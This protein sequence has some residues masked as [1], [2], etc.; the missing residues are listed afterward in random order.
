MV[1]AS[2]PTHWTKVQL[3]A[4]EAPEAP[5]ARTRARTASGHA[6]CRYGSMTAQAV[7]SPPQAAAA[8]PVGVPAVWVVS[9][10]RQL[11]NEHDTSGHAPCKSE[12]FPEPD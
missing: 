7:G 12:R 9:S 8:A 2:R 5:E 4:P 6:A 1:H 3:E 10:H 11:H